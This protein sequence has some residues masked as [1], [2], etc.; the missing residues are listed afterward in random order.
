VGLNRGGIEGE[1]LVVPSSSNLIV[2]GAVIVSLLA[3]EVGA[4]AAF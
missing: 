1:P 4:G 3:A 2:G